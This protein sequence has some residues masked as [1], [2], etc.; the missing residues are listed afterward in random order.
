M[1]IRNERVRRRP[2]PKD[3]CRCVVR[4]LQ[5][6]RLEGIAPFQSPTAGITLFRVET[7][8]LTGSLYLDAQCLKVLLGLM[9]DRV[10]RDGKGET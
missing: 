10:K 2:F 1:G 5:W 4:D 8:M 3:Y 6:S 7:L 9:L